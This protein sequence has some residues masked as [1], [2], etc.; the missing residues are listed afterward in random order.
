[1]IVELAVK[2]VI[3]GEELNNKEAIANPDSLKYFKDLRE[4]K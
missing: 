1:M 3:D 2:I 4:L